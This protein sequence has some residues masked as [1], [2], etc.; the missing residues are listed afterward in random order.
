MFR[1]AS[2]N[3][4]RK[5]LS[6]FQSI[7][8]RAI[9]SLVSA[10]LALLSF[11]VGAAPIPLT[12]LVCYPASIFLGIAALWAGLTAIRQIHNTDESGRSLAKIGIW[13]GGL[14]IL[15]IACAIALMVALWPYIS[16]L[17]QQIWVQI[18]A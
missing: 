2:L 18:T 17:I 7:N 12:A 4:M 5:E 13:V 6:Q 14:T 16:E 8:R 1:Q 15:F 9:L 11:C 3:A 10:V